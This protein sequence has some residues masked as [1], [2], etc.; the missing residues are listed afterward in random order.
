MAISW[1]TCNAATNTHTLNSLQRYFAADT[2]QKIFINLYN[3]PI[4]SIEAILVFFCVFFEWV[5]ALNMQ[6]NQIDSQS[7]AMVIRSVAAMH[8][9]SIEVPMKR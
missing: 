2:R 6:L 8:V 1:N 7:S 5:C 4:V 9:G 3:F